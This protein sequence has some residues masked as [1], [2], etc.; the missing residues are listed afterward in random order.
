MFPDYM[1]TYV[2][3]GGMAQYEL[4]GFVLSFEKAP[5][6]HMATSKGCSKRRHLRHRVRCMR[7]GLLQKAL[8]QKY[9]EDM[10]FRHSQ[11]DGKGQKGEEVK[12]DSV[13]KVSQ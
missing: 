1:H 8:D 2:A 4:N 10:R 13:P 7:C 5:W 9:V 11:S 12:G 6:N 3:S